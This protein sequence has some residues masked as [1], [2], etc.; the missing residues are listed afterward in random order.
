[1]ERSEA[2]IIHIV[3]N[4]LEEALKQKGL[5]IRI[6]D[7][8]RTVSMASIFDIVIYKGVTP[9]VI[10]EIKKS[11]ISDIFLSR[12]FEQVRSGM[13]ITNSRFGVVSDS[14][15]FYFYDRNNK[16]SNFRP[17][18]FDEVVNQ[19]IKPEKIKVLKKD[20]EIVLKLIT[21]AANKH[22]IGNKDFITY[23]E[24]KTFYNKIIF[25]YNS[26]SFHFTDDESGIN[27]FENQFFIKMFGEFKDTRICRYTTL[28]TL[29]EMLKN[30]SFRMSGLVG[31]NDKSEVNYVENYFE[32]ESNKTIIEKPLNKEHHNTITAIN[33]RYIT[34]CS[35]IKRKDD[36]TL[37]RL[38]SDDARGV[39][40]V[41]N[42]KKDNLNNHVLL[43][44][45]KYAD[46]N[47]KHKELDFIKEIIDKVEIE[48][49]F[50]FEF[51]KLSVWKH[52][53][54][55]YDYSIEEE[56]RLL[57]IDNKSLSELKKDWVM[58]YTHSIF[59]PVIDFRLN[60]KSF[61][62]Q[63]KEI[64]LGPKCPEYDINQVQIK[65]MVRRKNKEIL[66]KEYDSDLFG[67]KVEP[68][69]IKHYR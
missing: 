49:G 37:W 43:Q 4:R 5:R 22:L 6:E 2:E 10:I 41:F 66:E 59:N 15:N 12:A 44:K 53:F 61:P 20:K 52:F 23:L 32:K 58:T 3:A 19:I 7:R 65:E 36:L 42:V 1:M 11:I 62:I 38:Y 21:E 16:E 69:R 57:I 8:W 47:G 55:A 56:V 35:T 18:S 28:T 39:C 26:S 31:M 14:E 60:S 64:I 17:S 68:S 46:E 27:S 63:L 40:L 29:Y 45:V 48:T 30:I 9:L 51:R 67:L 13:S 24:N 50:K 54:K 25:D 34:S 33:N